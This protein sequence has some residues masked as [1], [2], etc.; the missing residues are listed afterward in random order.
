M[1]RNWNL[2]H[3]HMNF[4]LSREI[5]P[6]T[7]MKCKLMFYTCLS[8]VD[9]LTLSKHQN[10]LKKESP[11]L[12][13]IRRPKPQ[14]F[15]LLSFFFFINDVRAQQCPKDSALCKALPQATRKHTH[16][17]KSNARPHHPPGWELEGDGTRRTQTGQK[18]AASFERPHSLCHLNF[19]VLFW[20]GNH[21]RDSKQL[22]RAD[23]PTSLM[24][25]TQDIKF[26]RNLQET[27]NMEHLTQNETEN[28]AIKNR[29]KIENNTEKQK[30]QKKTKNVL[31]KDRGRFNSG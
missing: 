25:C 29:A 7:I 4:K 14:F 5:L 18:N 11:W 13:T 23:V 3:C 24:L 27:L 2:C 19:G 6:L 12:T 16:A 22:S 10:H 31:S 1:N 8:A 21:W 20:H 30:G 17:S 26:T 15:L 9:H 28:Q